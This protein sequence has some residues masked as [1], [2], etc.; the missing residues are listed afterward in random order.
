MS[1]VD[2]VVDAALNAGD[3]V[4]RLSPT[5]VPRSFCIPGKRLRLHP[6]DY[7]AFGAHRGGI[8]E[9]WFASTT[10][11]DNGP[12][13][14]PD[15]G[16]SYIYFK[17]GSKEHKVLL[18]DAI[19]SRGTDILGADVM[20]EHGGWTM[21]SKFFDNL[22]PLPHH[23]HP[24]D[25]MAANVGM[26]GKPEAYYFPPQLNNKRGYFPYTF[27]GINPGVT[28]DEV[29]TCLTN[30]SKGDNGIL[31]LSRAYRLKPG[32]GWDVP[33]GLLH[34]PGSFLTYEPQRASDVFAMFQS[35]V[36]DSYTPWELLVKDV[37]DEYKNDLD[38]I[39]SLIEWEINVDPDLY[40]N[41]F[42]P[43]KPVHPVEEMRKDGYCENW[44]TYKSDAFSAKE[45]TV[46]PGASVDIR[47]DAAYGLIVVQGHGEFGPLFVKAPTLIRFGHMTEDELFVTEKAAKAGVRI[48][49][50][51]ETDDLVILKH[52]G[53][54]TERTK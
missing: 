10:K 37:P 43:P 30:W 9:R 44:I 21:Y 1:T 38:Y 23:L 31:D 24:T 40:K 26:R 51:S 53:P 14:N 2:Q 13:T 12:E 33:P 35:I 4:F 28:K 22:E 11:A 20:R 48:T 52:F 47:D 34:A 46:Y 49:N 50:Q 16:L 19:E 54:A 32:T 18:S 17:D 5:W 6:D 45:L 15:E 36:W 7:Y 27:F 29:R 25:E 42:T 8:D 41:R 3:G 39:M